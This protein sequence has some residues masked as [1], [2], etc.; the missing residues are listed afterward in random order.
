[1]AGVCSV[2]S[3]YVPSYAQS[4]VSS[5]WVNDPVGQSHGTGMLDSNQGWSSAC[6][7]NDKACGRKQWWQ[8][9]VGDVK[10]VSGVVTQARTQ[11]DQYVKAFKV[12]VSSDGDTWTPVDGGF[13]FQGNTAGNNNNR[14][15]AKFAAGVKARYVRIKP[16]EWNRHIS[17]RAAVL[18]CGGL[19]EA[20]AGAGEERRGERLDDGV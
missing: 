19:S 6:Q 10:L 14:N 11:H 7:N 5:A 18:L 16:W 20:L 15:Y 4:S 1:M 13:I 2:S 17:M 3:V 9:D 12:D 8:M